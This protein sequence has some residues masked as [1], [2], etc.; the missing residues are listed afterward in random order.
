LGPPGPFDGGGRRRSDNCDQVALIDL[1]GPDPGAFHDAYRVY[2]LRSRLDREFGHHKNHVLWRG[3]VPLLGGADYVSNG[4]I[5]MDKW[6]AEVEKDGR[7]VPLAQKIIEDKPADVA[8]RCTE[9]SPI[10]ADLPGE[11][12]DAVVDLYASPRIEAGMPFTDDVMRCQRKPLRAAD[13]L[14]AVFTPDQWAQMEKTYPDGV[15]DYSKPGV[16]VTPTVPWLTYETRPGGSP[17][18]VP[19]SSVDL[20]ATGTAAL[21]GTGPAQVQGARAGGPGDG[22]DPSAQVL[23]SQ[24][25]RSDPATLPTTG[26]AVL[27]LAWTGLGLLVVGA[28]LKRFKR[29]AEQT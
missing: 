1:R 10:E 4:I 14:P 8:D 6:L 7:A 26:L 20:A 24:E 28:R 22:S 16:D 5:A 25:T 13:Y 2:A 3:F 18:G 15:C 12:C 21:R 27:G 19:P 9:G 11:A 17:L 29:R 23:G